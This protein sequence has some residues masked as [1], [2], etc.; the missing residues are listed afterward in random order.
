MIRY[1]NRISRAISV[2]LSDRYI[3]FP[4]NEESREEIKIGL[5]FKL[6]WALF[7]ARHNMEVQNMYIFF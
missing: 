6:E 5:V 1:I 3:H 7:T 4:Q 2:N